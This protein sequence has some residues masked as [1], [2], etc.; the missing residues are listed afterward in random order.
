MKKLAY[1]LTACIALGF[2]SCDDEAG[3]DGNYG[4]KIPVSFALNSVSLLSDPSETYPLTVDPSAK[5]DT[6]YIYTYQKR[7]TVFDSEGKPEIRPDG[8]MNVNVQTIEYEGPIT[9]RYYVYEPIV[10]KAEM[11]EYIVELSSNARWTVGTLVG[12]AISCPRLSGSGDGYTQFKLNLNRSQTA[13]RQSIAYIYSNDS[14]V[15]HKLTF[16]QKKRGE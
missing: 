10:V 13:R 1:F 12:T 9:A 11:D 4:E 3:P 8:S 6:T 14:T 5:T 7:D 16:E 15:M 2:A